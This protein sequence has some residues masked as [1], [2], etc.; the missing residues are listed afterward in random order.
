MISRRLLM[1]SPTEPY[2][3]LKLSLKNIQKVLARV[4]ASECISPLDHLKVQSYVLLAHAAF[5]QY[6]EEIVTLIS[7][8]AHSQLKK[9]N[10]VCRAMLS[11]V[12]SE[13]MQQVDDDIARRK[14][15]ASMASDLL[16]FASSAVSNL[17]LDIQAN[18]GVT[19]AD[20]KKLLL[21]IGVDP[22]QV[23]LNVSAALNAFGTKRGSIAHKVKMKTAETRSSVLSETEQIKKGLLTFDAA[24]CSQLREGMV[25]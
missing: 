24:A 13:A 9:E 18:H 5:E 22:E 10:R 25:K 3:S 16:G 14:I 12:A 8:E 7:R 1:K 2:K 19:T 11:L 21:Q 6:I 23:D 15:R 4:P 17:T 20:Q